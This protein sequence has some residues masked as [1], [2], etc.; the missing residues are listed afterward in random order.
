MSD[1]FEETIQTYDAYASVYAEINASHKPVAYLYDIFVE[2]GAAGRLLDV[3]CGHGRDTGHF[4]RRGFQATGVDRSQGLLEIARQTAPG[5][6]FCQGDMRRLPFA[7]DDF[8]ALWVC[9]SLLHLPK[10]DAPA[11]L[12][13]FRRVLAPG[14]VLYI[15]VKHGAGETLVASDAFDHAER[16]FAYYQAP[17][18]AQLV[19][20]AGFR[21]LE[22]PVRNGWINLFA[23]G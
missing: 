23:Q 13:E 11:A 4:A 16:F 6:R 18:L 17:E 21:L 14:G 1:P 3:G 12:A 10:A 7:T 2:Y 9:A 15:G 8:D 19:R 5:A 20:A 22:S